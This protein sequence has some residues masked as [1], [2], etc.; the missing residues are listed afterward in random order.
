M[1]NLNRATLE[2][3]TALLISEFS[4]IDQRRAL[5]ESA[6]FGS[7]IL[8]QIDFNGSHS[9]F[10]T[11][12]ISKLLQFG[13][14]EPNKPAIIAV[15]LELRNYVDINKRQEVDRIID[16][17]RSIL[18][19]SEGKSDSPVQT[20]PR[21][22]ISYS[23]ADVRFAQHLVADLK[24]AGINVWID[25]E[26]IQVGKDW[27]NVI[28]NA[29]QNADVFIFIASPNSR[30]SFQVRS[31]L[32]LAQTQGR[33]IYLV[34]TT[35]DSIESVPLETTSA[36]YIDLQNNYE[37]GLKNLVSAIFMKGIDEQIASLPTE[38]AGE[39]CDEVLFSALYPR[40]AEHS[41][42]YAFL[43][44]VHILD[45]QVS[46]LKDAEK[47]VEELGGTVPRPKISKEKPCLKENTPVTV[48]VECLDQEFEPLVLTK[49]WKNPWVRFG[50]DFEASDKLVGD[51]IIARVSIRV[52]GI[53]IASIGNCAIE[54]IESVT[55][56]DND[57]S[58]ESVTNPLALAK[59]ETKTGKMH[60]RIFVSYAREDTDVVES[61]RLAQEAR[62][63]DVFMDTYS[64]RAGEDWKKA[65]AHAIDTV[66]IFQLFWSEHS[67]QSEY[68]Q[69][70]WDYAIT[71][72]CKEDRCRDFIRPVYWKRPMSDPPEPL[73]HLNF[74]FVPFGL[75]GESLEWRLYHDEFWDRMET[76]F[77]ESNV[78]LKRSLRDL[79]RGQRAIYRRLERNHADELNS[80]MNA[81][82]ESKLVQSEMTETL[83][84]IE[85]TLLIMR[86]YNA[87]LDKQVREAVDD[88]TQA[89]ESNL[90]VQQKFELALPIVPF[91][92][93]YKVEL[94]TGSDVDLNKVWDDLKERWSRLVGR[95]RGTT[96]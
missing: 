51:T 13:D 76:Y 10:T 58:I 17:I 43:V 90:G 85:R 3:L 30:R 74:A 63:D 18:D 42:R 67:S 22:F 9:V 66:D 88:L 5:V 59:L 14:I 11:H 24:L 47:F 23:R 41:R 92:L 94:G 55:L 33:E 7:P 20:T 77:E 38:V 79:K 4:T 61:Y 62:G 73:K 89:V 49:R 35:D 87:R 1:S 64:I 57:S 29:I 46:I 71:F 68:V 91:F 2:K 78:I 84:S 19:Q 16:D 80:I 21:V 75:A 69:H 83:Q 70:E 28:D 65:L 44:Y 60:D 93:D 37:A 26:S 31:E 25:Y 52:Y 53:E 50:F 8:V 32:A 48:M 45:A 54:V 15:L 27:Q 39:R 56:Q 86:K 34:Q 81:L 40:V 95:I 96:D 36:Q 6:L 82:Q 72:R 12:L